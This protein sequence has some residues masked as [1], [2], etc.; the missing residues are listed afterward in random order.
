MPTDNGDGEIIYFGGD[1]HNPAFIN[2][3]R[4]VDA[5]RRM[6][7]V[8]RAITYV[9]S[10]GYDLFCSGHAQLA[11]GRLLV[12]GGTAFFPG[13][14]PPGLDPHGHGP[15][16]HFPGHR[17]ACVYNPASATMD[18]VAPMQPNP[19]QAADLGGGRWYPTL[20]T[21]A[22]GDVLI[23][24]GHPA[25][26]DNRHN[27]HT[28]ERY[29]PILNSWKVVGTLGSAGAGPDLYPRLHVLPTGEVFC[30]SR[31]AGMDHCFAYNAYTGAS[32][33]V[34]DLPAG[35]YHGFAFASVLLPLL[36]GDNYRPR[37]LLCGAPVP[38][39]INI[40]PA[41]GPRPAWVTAGS[42]T[43]AAAERLR[44]HC[45]AVLLPTGQV[46]VV[47]GVNGS[48]TSGDDNP[49]SVR[50]P[51]LYDPQIDWNGAPGGA[52]VQSGG[53]DASGTWTTISEPA[54]VTRN[55]HSTA[56]LMPDGSVWTSGS[57]ING[58]P[59]DPASVGRLNYEIFQPPY[60]AG[61]R[62][63]ILSAPRFVAWGQQ[64]TV[65]YQGGNPRR[66]VLVRCGSCTHAFDS[67]QRQVALRFDP[68]GSDR[69][70]CTAPPNGAV[71]PP[72]SYM[73]FIVDEAGRPC[74]RARFV[75]VG[76]S[77]YLVL[78]RSQFA[79]E[80]VS[81]LSPRIVG[82]ALL[83]V[84]D[85]FL[86]ADLALPAGPNLVFRWADGGALVPGMRESL[87]D[88]RSES[89]SFT[90]GLA[91]RFVLEYGVV[92]DDLNAFNDLGTDNRRDV[93]VS[94]VLPNNIELQGTLTLFRDAKPYMK[95]GD[96]PWL[97]IDVR[98]AQRPI[99]VPL[100][101]VMHTDA[102][103]GPGFVAEMLTRFNAAPRDDDHPFARLPVDQD[104]A[105]LELSSHVGG[106]RVFN[107]AFARVRYRAPVGRDATGVRMFFRMLSTVGTSLEYNETTLYRR[108][109]SGPTAVPQFGTIGTRTVSVPYFATPRGGDRLA[110]TDTPNVQDLRGQDA[111]EVTRF[112]GAW[113]DFNHRDDL[114]ALVRGEHQCL[115]AELHFPTHSTIPRGAAP[116]EHDSLSQRNLA[117]VE[118]DNPGGVAG[119]LVQHTFELAP[120]EV[121]EPPVLTH[122]AEVHVAVDNAPG[123][124]VTPPVVSPLGPGGPASQ[125]KLHTELMI[126]WGNLPR[127]AIATFYL[128]DVD[129]ESLLE[130]EAYRAGHGVFEL[131][132]RHTVRCQIGEVTFLPI[133]AMNAQT[134]PGMVSI[135][136]PPTVRDGQRFRVSVHQVSGRLFTRKVTGSFEFE[137]PVSTGPKLLVREERKL[138]VLRW[139]QSR[140]GADTSWTA[141]FERYVGQVA[142]RVRAFG[143]D[144]DAITPS[145]AGRPQD[146]PGHGDD[147]G[148]PPLPDDPCGDSLSGRG[149]R[150]RIVAVHY[151]C[152]GRLSGFDL[153]LCPGRR[154][155]H[156]RGKA[157]E[158]AILRAAAEQLLV[159]VHL[160]EP[161]R[162]CGLT[163]HY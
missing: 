87:L 129:F 90:P 103:A 30:S 12:A 128:P 17:S 105:R 44:R 150:G 106:V 108:V 155:I 137:I 135:Q 55:Y 158:V 4:N 104:A 18:D 107:Y 95:D 96:R 36:P 26:N 29:R 117:I 100:A 27:N 5:A 32:R 80:E 69:I 64:F 10:P 50:Q 120:F 121:I 159:T 49:F 143:G 75:R 66:A 76:G 60:P 72:G 101:G 99:G 138:A 38:Q 161:E 20:V 54:G 139:I 74:Q 98:V 16:G 85:G 22:S 15:A 42:R 111:A 133:P 148:E 19:G 140:L 149:P 6:N 63:E 65:L 84:L 31:H 102:N 115:V 126:R 134:L 71:A 91:Q 59:G 62:P 57:S 97:S 81:T 86:P 2:S 67:D 89:G 119:H 35:D 163:L 1:Q 41:S 123:V 3:P 157:L 11:D 112:F 93:I 127:D 160:C 77:A 21:L 131:I 47:G 83:L 46:L 132:D 156:A 9:R 14:I 152:H 68:S 92:F 43:I 162:A 23:M 37:V 73:L 125:R 79:R 153:D 28:P 145:S 39:R 45:L 113:L 136:L 61:T 70:V 110:A 40:G 154:R 58:R 53:A 82:D 142:D 88:V 146:R 114:R 51:E 33:N 25:E 109:G 48:N 124:I 52:Y 34:C 116:A 144:P 8:T 147:D 122:H 78:N 7:C 130:A 56:L 141:V 13:N 118:S 24:A 151:D 94:A